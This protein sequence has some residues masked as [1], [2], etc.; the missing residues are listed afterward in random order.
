MSHGMGADPDAGGGPQLL[1]R[2]PT[3]FAAGQKAVMAFTFRRPEKDELVQIIQDASFAQDGAG[4][5]AARRAADG[6]TIGPPEYCI[7]SFSPAAAVHELDQDC[8]LSGNVLPQIRDQRPNPHLANP[9]RSTA[10]NESNRLSLIEGS[11]PESSLHR[12][13]Q[14]N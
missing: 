6:Q 14:G 2:V 11:L 3:R 12:C 1:Q 10:A 13:Q 7:R 8:G 9:S 4:E 5:Y